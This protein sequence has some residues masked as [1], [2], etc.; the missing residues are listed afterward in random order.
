[1]RPEGLLPSA[2]RRP[3]DHWGKG[4]GEC[5]QEKANREELGSCSCVHGAQALGFVSLS[6][7]IC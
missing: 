4:Q 3:R 5:C 1:M 2:C 7:F 6:L